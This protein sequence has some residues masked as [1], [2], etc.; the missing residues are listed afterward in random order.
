[1]RAISLQYDAVLLAAWRGD[2]ARATDLMEEMVIAGSRRGEG[3]ALTYVDY[4][5]SGALQRLRRSTTEPPRRRTTPSAQTT[6][7]IS[8][9]ALP[10]LVEA[11]AR[12][13]QPDA[14]RC[15]L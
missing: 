7:L 12:S 5:Q 10:E 11:A 15:G 9:W 2:P 14:C 1:M 13:G 8:Y 3:V 6:F 4:R